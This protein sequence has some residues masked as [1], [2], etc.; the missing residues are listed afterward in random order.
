MKRETFMASLALISTA[1]DRK[2]SEPLIE[3]YWIALRDLTDEELAVA[4]KRALS[5]CTFMPVP[6]ELLGLAGRARSLDAD[7]AQAWQAVRSAIDKHDY[8]VATIDFGQLVNAVIRN[9]GGWDTLC[10]ASLSELDNPGWLRKRF[11]ELYRTLAPTN[12]AALAGE[13]LRGALPERFGGAGNVVVSIGGKTPA[14]RIT[15]GEPNSG[16]GIAGILAAEK[17]L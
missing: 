10:R 17:S 4:T 8:L 5:E 3:G 1:F 13:P 16:H 15:N 9:L 7:A 6:A 14:K 11:D 12:H 2:I